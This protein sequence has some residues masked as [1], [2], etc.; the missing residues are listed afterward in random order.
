M[1]NIHNG[2]GV[3][4]DQKGRGSTPGDVAQRR[5]FFRRRTQSLPP[6]CFQIRDG[7]QQ[8]QCIRHAFAEARV[9]CHRAQGRRQMTA[10]R[11]ADHS[12]ALGVNSQFRGVATQIG[13]GVLA[14]GQAGI[15]VVL[16]CCQTILHACADRSAQGEVAALG[17]P[18]VRVSLAPAAAVNEDDSWAAVGFLPFAGVDQ[19]ESQLLGQPVAL[20]NSLKDPEAMRQT[21][22]QFC[23]LPQLGQRDW[24]GDCFEPSCPARALAPK[25]RINATRKRASVLMAAVPLFSQ[26]IQQGQDLRSTSASLFA[27]RRQRTTPS[28][29]GTIPHDPR[30][31]KAP[32]SK[33]AVT[34]PF[35]RFRFF[36]PDRAQQVKWVGPSKVLMIRLF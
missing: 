18:L 32:N 4:M 2:I 10:G 12:D 33:S 24:A 25:T 6:L 3:A 29:P 17:K 19:I 8:D 11:F 15:D 35:R 9:N 28:D 27:S 1:A 31:F 34:S 30:P 13:N 21:L 16:S 26:E 7:I 22:R 5:V 36:E 23:V 20:R 14:V